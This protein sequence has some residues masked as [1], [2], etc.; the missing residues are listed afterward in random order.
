MADSEDI[1]TRCGRTGKVEV[2]SSGHRICGVCSDD[3]A[4]DRIRD[5]CLESSSPNPYIVFMDIIGDDVLKMH[6][7]K[8]HVAVGSA[9]LAAHRN[10]GTDID[11]ALMLDEM[12]KRGSK[13]PPGSCG[14]MG[15]CGA[16]VSVGT[17]LSILT[18]TT[19]YS[20]DTWGDVNL[21]TA[22][23]LIQMAIVG[24]PR[25]C[26]RNSFIA[27]KVG[28]RISSEKFGSEMDIPDDPVCNMSELNKECIRERCPFYKG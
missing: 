14:L 11:L 28:A 24:G 21:A 9:L 27:L 16:A 17:F 3:M 23:C 26:K 22:Q 2:C 10:S 4:L 5:I 13:V 6:D 25:C 8:H 20:E 12:R 18:G 19:P 15:N 7:Y 1:C